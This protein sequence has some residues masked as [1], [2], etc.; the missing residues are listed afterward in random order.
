MAHDPAAPAM[1]ADGTHTSPEGQLPWLKY[2]PAGVTAAQERWR[3]R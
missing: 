1:D 2:D 3:Q